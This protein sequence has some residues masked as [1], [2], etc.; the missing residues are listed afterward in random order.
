[1]QSSQLNAIFLIAA[2]AIS[3]GASAQKIYKC[4]SSYS[5]APCV[6]GLVVDTADQRSN[7]QKTQTDLAT[8][9]DAKVADAMEAARLKKE[10]SDLAANTPMAA[11]AEPGVALPEA[12]PSIESKLKANKKTPTP[13]TAQVPGTQKKKKNLNKKAKAAKKKAS[14]A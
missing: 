8:A 12:A 7:A 4:G 6:G 5:Q 3:T 13:F 10:K 11:L 9:R 2:C 1:M 14:N